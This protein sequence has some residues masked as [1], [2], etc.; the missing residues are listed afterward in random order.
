MTVESVALRGHTVEERYRLLVDAISDYAIYMLDPDGYISSWNAGAHRFKGYTEEEI[1]GQHFSRFYTSADRDAG[2]PQR[3][4]HTAATEGRFEAEGWR[5]RKDSS[6][7]WAHVIIDAIRDPKGQLI[8]FAKITRDLTERKRT[9]E[10]LKSSEEQFRLLVQGVVDYAIYMLDPQGYVSSWNLGAQRIK[11]YAPEEIIGQ[12]FSKFYTDEDKAQNLPK[13]ALE[14]AERE[15]RFEREGWRI[16]KDGTRFWANVII[17][18]IHADD[19]RLIGFAKITRD[20]TEKRQAE[21]TLQRAQQELFQA[22]KMEALGQLTGGVAHDFNNL[23]TAILGSLEIAQK[24]AAVGKD[25]TELIKNAIQ[26]ARRGASLT[27]RLLAFSRKQ[28]L[29]LEAVDIPTLVRGMAEM[30]RRSIGPTIEINTSFPLALSRVHSDPN[31]LESALLNLALNARDA[32]PKGGSVVIAAKEHWLAVGDVGGLKPGH[33]VCLSVTDDGEGMDVATLES[34]TSP[35]F[36]TKGAGKGTGLGLPMV[37]G[38][39]AQSGGSLVLRS[40]TGAGTT[41]ELWLPVAE[42]REPDQTKAEVAPKLETSLRVLVVDDDPLVLTNAALMIE[43][44]GHAAVEAQSAEEALKLLSE[45]NDFDLVV[46]DH[47]MPK[48]TGAELAALLRAS[49]PHL[50]VILAT[51]YADLPNA[52][53]RDLVRLPKPFSQ[54]QLNSSIL[55]AV[56]DRK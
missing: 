13:I 41:A 48:M 12:H 14:N 36:T 21:E 54:A 46:T 26:G 47:A 23:L 16:R 35:F 37:Q 39:M 32:M 28:E 44:L 55:A 3:A 34:A 10:V 19:G 2:L 43:D 40:S 52:S 38:L 30:L 51:G 8:G 20:I 5:V 33:Y 45:E 15:G 27:Q 56:L 18:A 50:P 42:H 6:R 22:Q 31:Q 24:R 29:T 17:D 11:G 4:L 25:V 53:D 9:E 49:H 1:L 7:F